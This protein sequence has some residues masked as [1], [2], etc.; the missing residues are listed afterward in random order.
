MLVYVDNENK[1]H[2]TNETGTYAAVETSFFDGKCKEFIEG[3]LCVISEENGT[4][5]ITPWKPFSELDAAQRA[6]E[7]QMLKEYEELI[8]ELYAEVTA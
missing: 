4:R 2:V 7:Q 6:Y 1:C 8:D 3:F 5:E